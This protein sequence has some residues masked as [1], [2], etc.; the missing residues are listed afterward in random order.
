ML[1]YLVDPANATTAAGILLSGVS[2]HFAI[3][4]RPDLAVAVALWAM[5]ADQLDG[6]L[7]K[8]TKNRSVDKAK[9]GKSLDGFADI[10]YG[11]AIP[12]AVIMVVDEA[13]VRSMVIGVLLLLAGSLRLSYFDNFGLTDGRF[14]G[15]PLSYDVPVLALLFI[16]RPWIAEPAFAPIVLCVFAIIG[17]L[18]VASIPVPAPGR[19]MYIGI[20]VFSTAASAFLVARSFS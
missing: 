8:R 1:R 4:G 11:A 6:I 2:L 12:A 3:V 19:A 7:A 17:C 20:S 13:S 9:I 5:L 15:V 16:A 18:H 14:T 10:I